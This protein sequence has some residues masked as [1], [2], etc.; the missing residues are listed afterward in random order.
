MNADEVWKLIE[1]EEEREKYIDKIDEIIYLKLIDVNKRLKMYFGIE[2]PFYGYYSPDEGSNNG[3]IINVTTNSNEIERILFHFPDEEPNKENLVFKE[4]LKK[5]C[6][7]FADIDS[8]VY[9]RTEYNAVTNKF[10]TKEKIYY[11]SSTLSDEKEFKKRIEV[12]RKIKPNSNKL[13]IFI[14]REKFKKLYN[15]K[16]KDPEMIKFIDDEIKGIIEEF[17][18]S[19]KLNIDE[20]INEVITDTIEQ[21]KKEIKLK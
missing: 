3:I 8:L 1:N 12:I 15:I 7:F 14:K 10:K 9:W 11:S 18:N 13:K 16:E 2:E 19:Y 21:I 4:I 6:N 5:K 17:T 20:K